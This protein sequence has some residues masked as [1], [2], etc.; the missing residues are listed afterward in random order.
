MYV[1]ESLMKMTAAPAMETG[2]EV[3][4]KNASG[5]LSVFAKHGDMPTWGKVAFDL[6]V[7]DPGLEALL[8]GGALLG[9]SASA[10]GEPSAATTLVPEKG[11]EL[12]KATYGYRIANYNSFG[13]SKATVEVAGTTLNA[14]A[15]NT[16]VIVPATG[17]FTAGTLGLRVFGRTGGV[18]QY[19]GTIPNIGKQKLE[20]AIAAKEAKNKVVIVIKV[21]ALT[22]SIPKGTILMVKGD[23]S[24]PKALLKTTIFGAKG[25]TV[26][27]VENLSVENSAKIEPEELVPVFVDTGAIT[28]NGGIPASD[29]TAGPAENLG[30]NAPELG[31][32]GNEN[33][34]SIECFAKSISKGVQTLTQ[35]FHHWIFPRCTNFHIATRDL[36]NANAA[37]TIEGEAF[38][39]L[40][41]GSGPVGDWPFSS[42][43][44]YGRARCARGI[45]P[46]NQEGVNI[47]ATL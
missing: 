47:Q 16:T 19:I 8:T 14:V 36:T 22:E 5:N 33:G 26:L 43:K 41:W 37:T 21:T 2:D 25:A 28:P 29:T 35:P 12:A 24:A 39:N 42:T 4:I 1:T 44:W 17:T 3:K 23:S 6:V 20:T 27:E 15:E 32:V 30:T 10:L 38:Q 34:V 11:G 18:Q 13:E 9:S 7:P 31:I 45:V 40:N 46:A